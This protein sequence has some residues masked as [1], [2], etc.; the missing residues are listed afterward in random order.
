MDSIYESL[1]SSSEVSRLRESERLR[2][3]VFV[4]SLQ[5]SE[6]D[7]SVNSF[8]LFGRS[9]PFEHLSDPRPVIAMSR[10]AEKCTSF[11]S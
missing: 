7:E 5:V 8:G 6:D 3:F 2:P 1:H 10:A 4:S 9:R 11:G